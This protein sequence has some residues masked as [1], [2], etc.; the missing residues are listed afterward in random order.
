MPPKKSKKRNDGSSSSSSRSPHV[1]RKRGPVKKKDNKKKG[2]RPKYNWSAEQREEYDNMD[3]SSDEEDGN[4]IVNTKTTPSTKQSKKRTVTFSDKSTTIEDK[5]KYNYD[6]SD[7]DEETTPQKKLPSDTSSEDNVSDTIYDLEVMKSYLRM[8]NNTVNHYEKACF[9]WKPNNLE[10]TEN[11]SIKDCD[12]LD[13]DR[14]E[15][16]V[17]VALSSKHNIGRIILFRNDDDDDDYEKGFLNS[18]IDNN[19]NVKVLV[20]GEEE[21]DDDDDEDNNV[22]DVNWKCVV[23]VYYCDSKCDCKWFKCC[24]C[25]LAI[26]HINIQNI[27]HQLKI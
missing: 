26:C 8:N 17:R 5:N 16:C 13:N 23:G 22:I 14:R 24:V 21:D 27:S 11:N 15:D 25:V 19:G 9:L 10:L 7:S 6:E 4:D 12:I 20:L 18:N 2:G 1:K 3:K